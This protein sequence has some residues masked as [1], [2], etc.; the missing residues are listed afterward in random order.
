MAS[1]LTSCLFSTSTKTQRPPW[2]TWPQPGPW[3]AAVGH[4]PAAVVEEVAAVIVVDVAL[5]HDDGLAV[6]GAAVIVDPHVVAVHMA[7]AGVVPVVRHDVP[8]AV[9]VVVSAEVAVDVAHLH[10][11]DGV[12]ISMDE[13]TLR[14]TTLSSVQRAWPKVR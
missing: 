14:A 6:D 8:S 12:R 13:M 5:D 10:H 2:F 9:I 11:G 3:R 4:V 1:F 7:A